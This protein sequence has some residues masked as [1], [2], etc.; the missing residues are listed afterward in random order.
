MIVP[1]TRSPPY[2]KFVR[3]VFKLGPSFGLGLR[4]FLDSIMFFRDE[5]F[6]PKIFPRKFR[7]CRDFGNWK[8][9]QNGNF[10]KGNEIFFPRSK[11]SDATNSWKW[12]KTIFWGLRLQVVAPDWRNAP[13][14]NFQNWNK[15]LLN[16]LQQ[17]RIEWPSKWKRPGFKSCCESEISVS[18]YFHLKFN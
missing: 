4:N 18:K 12:R 10:S 5:K 8:S 2:I 7:R 13:S 11:T 3:V 16:D 1:A 14:S 9:D 15:Q 6:Q 17:W